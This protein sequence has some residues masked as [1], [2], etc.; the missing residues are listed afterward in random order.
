MPR[1]SNRHH[2]DHANVIRLALRYISQTK[3]SG[4]LARIAPTT[5][6]RLAII[7]QSERNRRV[8]W[9]IGRLCVCPV[10]ANQ[11][12]ALTGALGELLEESSE[13]L[14]EPAVSEFAA[15]E[16]TIT[17]GVGLGGCRVV[18]PQRVATPAVWS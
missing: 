3:S 10:V 14:V 12:N 17:P 6:N 4:I 9:A 7:A 15:G 16:F 5:S 2:S 18:N 11:R 13:S 1:D 8:L